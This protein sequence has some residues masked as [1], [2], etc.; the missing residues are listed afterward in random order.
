MSPYSIARA[1]HVSV[2]PL[3]Q[4]RMM[5]F[6]AVVPMLCASLGLA[7]CSAAHFTVRESPSD[8]GLYTSLFPYYAEFCALSEI[9]KKP[10]HGVEVV[11]G[12]PGGHSVLYLNGVCRVADAGYPTIAL[13][14]ES[15]SMEGRGVGIS[16]NSHFQNANWVATEGRQFFFHG[17]VAPGEGLTEAGYERTQ[18]KAQRMGILDGVV[19]HPEVIGEKSA[20]MSDR[21]YMYEVSVAT[22]YAIAFGRDRYCARVPMDRSEMGEIVDYL[23]RLNQ[24]YRTGRREFEWDVLRN[25][26]A[27]MVHN[28][29]AAVGLW[30]DWP[31]DRFV[32]FAAFD[33]PVPKN[34][35]VNLVRRTN[36]MPLAD[37]HALYDDGV[38]RASLL[39]EGRIATMPGALAQAERAI[40]PNEIYDTDLRLIFYDEPVFGHYQQWFDRIF[41]ERRYTD[42][43][44]NLVHFS[45]L[46][47][48]ILADARIWSPSNGGASDFD[49]FANR[50][51]DYVAHQKVAVDRWLA[52][53]PSDKP[54]R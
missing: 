16:V 44:A 28:A 40:R 49:R 19:F 8:E 7:A 13:C 32:L 11:G 24:P 42:L 33:F 48:A 2:G 18:A 34:E 1:F 14:P 4:G 17:D 47:G 50:Y 26:C 15:G 36:D 12:G 5:R 30:D 21:D 38:A 45:E 31:T 9:K 51:R 29:L 53:L 43:R 41:T 23:N 52:E 10:D 37:L 3:D 20:G 25:N 22:D 6:R 46:Y 35:F 27:H 54:M 39:R